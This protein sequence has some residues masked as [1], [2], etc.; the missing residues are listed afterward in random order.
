MGLVLTTQKTH[1]G[2]DGER[3]RT[4][5]LKVVQRVLDEW[6]LFRGGGIDRAT[7]IGIV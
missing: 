3:I 4:V 5:G 7:L 1:R 6:H 2:G